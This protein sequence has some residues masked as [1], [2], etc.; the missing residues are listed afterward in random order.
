M[1]TKGKNNMRIAVLAMAAVALAGCAAAP[2]QP[3]AATPTPPAAQPTPNAP[4]AGEVKEF[5]MT[6]FY[7][8]VDGKPKPQFSLKEMAVKKGDRVR[9][10][11]T[12]TRGDHD[13]KIDELNVYAETPLDQEVTVEFTA[14]KT[15]EFVYYC[16]KPNHRALGQW[17]TLRVTE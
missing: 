2:A 9:V 5:A 7:E 10:K 17:G 8:M 16:A 3:N 6:S 14:D 4:T 15:G 12:N 1:P 11:I 13:F